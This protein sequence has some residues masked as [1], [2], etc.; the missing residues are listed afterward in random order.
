MEKNGDERLIL[1]TGKSLF[2]T[3]KPRRHIQSC[4]MNMDI[5]YQEALRKTQRFHGRNELWN[6]VKASVEEGKNESI[7][8]CR[9]PLKFQK[10]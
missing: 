6:V 1:K 3:W 7:L 5:E 8:A 4:R 9:D 2:P 10:V